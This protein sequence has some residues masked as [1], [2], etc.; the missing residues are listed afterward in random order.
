M[1]R[2]AAVVLTAAAGG[3]IA[4]LLSMFLILVPGL[5]FHSSL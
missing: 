4:L 5:S 1:D 3:L 2:G